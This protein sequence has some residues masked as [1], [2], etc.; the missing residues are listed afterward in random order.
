MSSPNILVLVCDHHRF[1]ALGCMGNPL[2]RTPNLDRL[3]A[4][5]VRFTNC[6]NQAPVCAPARHAMATGRYTHAHGVLTNR[7]PPHP[8]MVTIAHALQPQAYRSVCLGHMHWTDPDMDTGYEDY[9]PFKVWEEDMPPEV[10]RRWAWED[11]GVTRR[12]TGGP[13]PRTREQTPGYHL[14]QH[15]IRQIES[16]VAQDRPFL[17]WTAFLEPHPPFYPPRSYYEQ[18][19]QTQIQL[20][21]QAPPDSPSPHPYIESMQQEWAHLTPVEI[22]QVIAGYYGLVTLVDECCGMILDTLDRLGIRDDTIIVWTSDHGDQMWEHQLFTKFNMYDASVH[23]PLLIDVPGTSP[24]VRE[25]L[26]EHID[27]F[28]TLCD[29]AGVQIP[30]TVQ[31]RSLQP[32]LGESPAPADWRDAVFS[33]ID[34]LQMIRTK[35]HK[36]NVYDGIP[37]ELYDLQ[38]DSDEFYNRLDD[39]G[40]ADV[41]ADLLQKLKQRMSE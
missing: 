6:F 25:D 28:P 16:A 15:T 29:L 20:P 17:C 24:A 13:S 21:Q 14:A 41:Q 9:I 35:N 3:A 18:I 40:Y 4:R 33:Q 12:T 2:A 10:L 26:V 32:L 19:D 11:Q 31:G 5:S 39:P 7:H 8:G 37:G 1:D 36:L 38:A 23:V 34:T 30:N 27:L 22:R